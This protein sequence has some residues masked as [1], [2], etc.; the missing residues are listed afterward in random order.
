MFVA[1]NESNQRSC[2]WLG[3]GLVKVSTAMISSIALLTQDLKIFKAVLEIVS[4]VTL[5]FRYQPI[6]EEDGIHLIVFYPALQTSGPIRFSLIHTTFWQYEYNLIDTY[7]VLSYLWGDSNFTKM[8]RINE[9]PVQITVN[10]YLA[11]VDERQRAA[12]SCLGRCIVY[13]PTRRW[14]KESTGRDDGKNLRL[15]PSYYYPLL[16]SKHWFFYTWIVKQAWSWRVTRGDG[17]SVT[18]GSQYSGFCSRGQYYRGSV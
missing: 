11:L 17:H 3:F 12:I 13:Q 6:I 5:P 1:S 7:T 14:G 18:K 8:V 2:R 15:S 16:M 4:S 9:S 10:L